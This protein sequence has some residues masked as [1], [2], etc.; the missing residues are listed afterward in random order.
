MY[1]YTKHDR[2]VSNIF[3]NSYLAPML[4]GISSQR[5]RI[6]IQSWMIHFFCFIPLSVEQ[7]VNFDNSKLAYCPTILVH[8]P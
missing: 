5:K 8:V 4:R 7:S 2:L 6:E 3:K 1:L